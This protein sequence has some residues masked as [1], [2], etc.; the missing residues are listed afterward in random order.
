MLIFGMIVG[1]AVQTTAFISWIVDLIEG[2]LGAAKFEDI[3]RAIPGWRIDGKNLCAPFIVSIGVVHGIKVFFPV[4]QTIVHFLLGALHCT[5][6]GR[7]FHCNRFQV[8]DVVAITVLCN[9]TSLEYHI[10]RINLLD[11]FE[12]DHIKHQP[13]VIGIFWIH[14]NGSDGDGDISFHSNQVQ[15]FCFVRMREEFPL[16]FLPE[17]HAS[18]KDVGSIQNTAEQPI[19]V[20]MSEGGPFRT[21][22]NIYFTV[23]CRRFRSEI[24]NFEIVRYPLCKPRGSAPRESFSLTITESF[25]T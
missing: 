8:P 14:I 16:V 7:E 6:D 23:L 10:V 15:L 17:F 4:S 13:L 22:T 12:V 24:K 25:L 19:Q 5:H 11:D 18:S 3:F 20:C 1:D 2:F 9:N 21:I